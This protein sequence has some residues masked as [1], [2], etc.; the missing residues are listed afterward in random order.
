MEISFFKN[1]LFLNKNQ[2]NDFDFHF[3][4]EKIFAQKCIIFV[5]IVF[6][7]MTKGKPSFKNFNFEKNSS[8]I[9]HH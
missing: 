8:K 9:F 5:F 2:N 7:Q 1:G 4:I 3:S 6:V